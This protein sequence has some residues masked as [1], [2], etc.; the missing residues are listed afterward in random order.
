MM[1]SIIALLTAVVSFIC[2]CFSSV[3]DAV[4]FPEAPQTE[5]VVFAK[6]L[7]N[8]WNLGNSLDAYEMDSEE[9]IG[10]E[11]EI[12]WGNPYT[13]KE[14][15]ETVK[16]SG[17]NT[18]R[19]PITWSQHLND[20]HIIDKAWLERVRQIVDWVLD[21]GMYAIIN[22]HHDDVFWLITDKEHEDNATKILTAIWSQVG[23]YFADYD[24]RLVF[25]T[26]NEP[27]VV[28][29]ESE[30]SGIPEHYE[31]VNNLNVAALNAIRK[32][33]GYNEKRFVIITTYAAR[34]EDVPVSALR[35]PEDKHVLVSVHCYYGTAHRSEFLDCE[36]RLTL[37]DKSEIYI[38]FRNLYRNFLKKG[39]GVVLGEFGWTDRTNLENLAD[40]AEFFIG[41]ANKF[42]MPCIVWDN[43]SDFRLFD[44]TTQTLE[45]PEYIKP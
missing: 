27:R 7:V 44:R 13:T 6:N 34:Y 4:F 29:I 24:E 2:G 8:G 15:I 32:S 17:F 26:M 33:G 12:Y 28:G 39:Y 14:M 31:I 19:I 40:R 45:F 38:I 5:S 43:G 9:K 25:E 22:V 18:V 35:L 36:N 10:C 37:L 1:K 21:C 30:W 11:S 42:G 41:T 20:E 3:F 23:E 16:K